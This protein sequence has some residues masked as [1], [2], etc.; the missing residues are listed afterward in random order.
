M[1]DIVRKDPGNNRYVIERDGEVIGFTEYRL[2][3]RSIV[4]IH[5]EVDTSRR[6]HGLPSGL[7]QSALDDVR[8][9]T[10]LR[11]VAQCPYVAHWVSEHPDYQTLLSR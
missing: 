3:D 5:T 11:V 6:E 1:A 10:D 4:F 2:Q 9:N 7:V 8:D